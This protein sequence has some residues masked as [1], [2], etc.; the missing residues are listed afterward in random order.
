MASIIDHTRVP[1]LSLKN[2]IEGSENDKLTFCSQLFE[3]IKQFGFIILK[4]HPISNDLLDQAYTLSQ[5]LFQLTDST[6]AHY[7]QK[8]GGQRGYTPFGTEHAKDCAFPDLKEF[9]HIG[10]N[11]PKGSPQ[12]ESFPENVWPNEIENFQVTFE[13]L[14]RKLDQTGQIILEAL[15][16]SLKIPQDFFKKFAGSGNSI[17]RLLHYP[18]I[19]ENADP[20]SVRAAA[21][22]DINLITILVAATQ[23]GLE[24]LDRNGNWMAVETEKNNLIVDAGDMLSRMTNDVIPS[25]TH[26]VVN[27]T[28]PNVSRYS[29]PF[30]IHPNS[31]ASLKCLP[32]C[33]GDGEKYADI[34]A[35]DFLHQRLREI[36]LM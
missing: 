15:T 24:L 25:T 9:W 32:S 16:P 12:K 22:E 8:N 1:E 5:K 20:N 2:Y 36:G 27:P 11:L 3:G 6:K 21:H 19:P 31:D 33:I 14:F 17:L 26:R 30:F 34:L 23:T 35:N 13:H 4:D 10:R 29:M 7:I 18:P 28:G